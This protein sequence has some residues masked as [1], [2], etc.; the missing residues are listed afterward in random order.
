MRALG[1][2]PNDIGVHSIRKGAA[3]YACS[4]STSGPSIA[5]VCN[6]AGWTMGKVKDTYIRY[7]AA[8]DQFV[9]RIVAGLNIN[10]RSFAV[11]PPFFLSS[12][13]LH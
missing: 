1:I 4:G 8:Q 7:E 3:T 2:D 13:E 10:S 6:R 5:A 9:G 11:S 12:D